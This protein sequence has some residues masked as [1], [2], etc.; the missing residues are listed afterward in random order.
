M[1]SRVPEVGTTAE[2][3]EDQPS[4]QGVS[5]QSA[6]KTVPTTREHRKPQASCRA[7]LCLSVICVLRICVPYEHAC[8]HPD[9]HVQ[10]P[11]ACPAYSHPSEVGAHPWEDRLG[12]RP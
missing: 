3:R 7:S 1:L 6:E 12:K 11:S 2:E 9:R 5:F 10:A 4:L 8:G